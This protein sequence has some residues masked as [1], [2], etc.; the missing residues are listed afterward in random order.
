MGT[1]T[2]LGIRF[3][4][5]NAQRGWFWLIVNRRGD[6]GVVGAAAKEAD[7][8]REARLS[9]EEMASKAKLTYASKLESL[10]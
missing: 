8:I 4:V 9:I 2:Y 6:A 3:C 7:A 1:D 5:W 10:S